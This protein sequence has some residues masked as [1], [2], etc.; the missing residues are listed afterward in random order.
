VGV[1]ERRERERRELRDRI[2]AAAID[3]IAAEGYENLSIRKLARRIEYSPRTIYLYFSDKEELL[4]DVV[5]E[6]F[7][8]TREIR[9]ARE[10]NAAY[11]R[12]LEGMSPESVLAERV[13]AHVEAAFS[14]PNV[15]RA[16][17]AVVFARDYE[18]GEAQQE[19]LRQTRQEIAR[20]VGSGDPESESIE[21]MTMTL[22][23]SVRAFTLSLLN[24][25]EE[26]DEGVREERVSRFIA[27][28]TKG[29]EEMYHE[30]EAQD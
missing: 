6:G 15:Y 28:L 22:F 12:S 18:P 20:L 23:A 17:I 13:R 29:L 5:E 24:R 11:R 10:E 30:R 1:Q 2:R 7:R 26:R 9:R 21:V 19:I 27:F 4:R 14:A 25:D 16:V 3:V 8:R